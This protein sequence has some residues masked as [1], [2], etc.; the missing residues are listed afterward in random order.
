MSCSGYHVN[1]QNQTEI[2]G[3]PVGNSM[4]SYA[5]LDVAFSQSEQMDDFQ[6]RL[7]SH[8]PLISQ[9]IADNNIQLSV[10]SEEKINNKVDEMI[11]AYYSR[12]NEYGKFTGT[13]NNQYNNQHNNQ[14]NNQTGIKFPLDRSQHYPANQLGSELLENFNN[15][16]YQPMSTYG[17]SSNKM[18]FFKIV[19]IIVIIVALVYGGY[20]LY[21]NNSNK[22]ATSDLGVTTVRTSTNKL[23]RN[24][25]Y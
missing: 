6:H 3:A 21:K 19:L 5:P 1:T 14:H 8:N 9:K 24:S 12:D 17:S 10:Q 2:S 20:W 16:Y 22:N 13:H 23:F 18:S 11:G 4:G 15:Q 7:M 25:M